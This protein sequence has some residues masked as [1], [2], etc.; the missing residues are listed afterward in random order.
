MVLHIFNA[1]TFENST[2][3]S[4]VDVADPPVYWYKS[5]V[6]VLKTIRNMC[7]LVLLGDP[8]MKGSIDPQEVM[9]HKL[10]TTVLDNVKAESSRIGHG[11]TSLMAATY[12]RLY[13]DI[14]WI[15][16]RYTLGNLSLCQICQNLII[17]GNIFLKMHM[18][19]S[20]NCFRQFS[21]PNQ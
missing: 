15:V 8:R 9:T 1:W 2:R 17:I 16:S 4:Y 5:G 14:K 18:S 7:F 20:W 19:V 3:I 13:I 21:G 10:R 11:R 12:K 6:S